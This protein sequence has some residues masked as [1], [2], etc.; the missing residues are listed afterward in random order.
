M[1]A[2]TLGTAYQRPMQ[3]RILFL[4]EVGE[5]KYRIDRLLTQL[6]LSG[7]FEGVAGIIVGEIRGVPDAGN[8]QLPSVESIL[9]ERLGELGVPLITGFSFGHGPVSHTLPIGR[10]A[11]IDGESRCVQLIG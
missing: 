2:A 9:A 1:I 4:E 8:S 5:A 10:F 7:H 3:G 11:E 6:L